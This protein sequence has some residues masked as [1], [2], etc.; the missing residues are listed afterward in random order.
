PGEN[1][2]RKRVWGEMGTGGSRGIRTSHDYVRRG[3][4]AARMMLLQAAANQ[5]QVPVGEL[6]V[7]NGVITHPA[8]QRI[9][10][11]GKVAAAAA[12]LGAPDAKAIQLKDPRG[13]K[14][15]RK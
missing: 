7:A 1:V 9:T 10:S 2:A 13:R 3:G 5:W 12:R 8:S 6:S 14:R 4:A 11:Y 15:A